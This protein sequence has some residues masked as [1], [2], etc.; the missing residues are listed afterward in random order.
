L[1]VGEIVHRL[2]GVTP[3]SLFN[4]I[5]GGAF[6][7]LVMLLFLSLCLNLLEF[8]DKKNTLI[9]PEIK[10]ESRFYYPI[11]EIMPTIYR[12]KLFNNE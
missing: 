7:L 1:L 11:Y 12:S 6:G 10:I 5:G 2:I 4:H 3:L 8:I 9:S